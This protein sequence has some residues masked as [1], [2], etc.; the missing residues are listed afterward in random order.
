MESSATVG[1]AAEE[2][3]IKHLDSEEEGEAQQQSG[4]FEEGWEVQQQLGG[5]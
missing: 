4:A 1:E 2:E 3:C 5:F